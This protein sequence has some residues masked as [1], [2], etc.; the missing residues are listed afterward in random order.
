MLKE[1]HETNE[2]STPIDIG[3]CGLHTISRSLQTGAK[4]TDWNLNKL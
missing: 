1:E 4:A 3:T 2:S